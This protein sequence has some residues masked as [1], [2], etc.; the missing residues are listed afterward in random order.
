[1]LLFYVLMAFP[2][3]VAVGLMLLAKAF[4]RGNGRGGVQKE[5]CRVPFEKFLTRDTCARGSEII[6]SVFEQ[7][8]NNY[9]SIPVK[10]N[11]KGKYG[12]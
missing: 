12:T 1:M 2:P 9:A 6:R 4:S 5:K 8:K 3:I 10:P 7:G 11:T